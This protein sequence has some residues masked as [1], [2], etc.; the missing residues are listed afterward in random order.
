LKEA[1]PERDGIEGGQEKDGL[2]EAGPALIERD[3]IEG[4]REE[5]KI[6]HGRDEGG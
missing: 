3:G 5:Q 4:G 6:E 2:E 1:E